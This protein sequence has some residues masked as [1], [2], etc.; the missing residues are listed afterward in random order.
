[1]IA[2]NIDVTASALV[3]TAALLSWKAEI[4]EKS[5]IPLLVAQVE[6]EKQARELRLAADTPQRELFVEYL[7]MEE[8][9]KQFS[10]MYAA[11]VH[12]KSAEKQA[13]L[14][15]VNGAKE[16]AWH[17]YEEAVLAHEFGHAWVR[18]VGYPAPAFVNNQWAC[19]GVH[20]GDIT[21][22]VLIRGEMD[23]R[24]IDHRTFWLKTLGEATVLMEKGASPPVEDRCGRVRLAAQLVDVRL[25]L[26]PQPEFEQA[27]KKWM[28]EVMGTVEA[29]V[30]FLKVHDMADKAEHREALKFV[31]EK[32]KDLAYQRTKDYRVYVTLIE[33]P[34]VS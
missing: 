3:L 26:P 22:H 2:H 24:G 7:K 25:G 33:N 10:Q 5:G 29:I 14:V 13:Y 20:T 28:P 23:R 21:Q 19:V 6:Y 9:T 12:Y 15:M 27:A 17:G 31:F 8:F 11:M 1:M 4:E 30:G 32:L 18:A 34:H 16:D